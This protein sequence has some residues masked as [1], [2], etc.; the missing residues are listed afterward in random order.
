MKTKLA[1]LVAIALNGWSFLSFAQDSP[2]LASTQASD[3]SSA[4]QSTVPAATTAADEPGTAA[5]GTEPAAE[6]QAEKSAT[7]D[8]VQVA[9][10]ETSDGGG[11]SPEVG[12]IN[13]PEAPL[14]DVIST[15]A[16]Q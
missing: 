5:Q 9:A 1:I 10:A 2:P 16:R 7:Q 6:K 11:T 15:L 14:T 4:P 8:S 12:S 13:I 3:S